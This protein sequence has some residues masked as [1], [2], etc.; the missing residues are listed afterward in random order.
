MVSF[1]EQT[2]YFCFCW[3]RHSRGILVVK[4]ATELAGWMSPHAMGTILGRAC[5]NHVPVTD[6][7]LDNNGKT[8][9]TR[10]GGS[11]GSKEVCQKRIATP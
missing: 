10:S 6:E 1:P 2:E 8:A 7:L 11:G 4:G 5:A 3:S 9:G